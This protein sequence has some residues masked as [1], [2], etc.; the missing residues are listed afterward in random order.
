MNLE[1]DKST[2]NRHNPFL[3]AACS[4][5]IRSQLAGLCPI[6]E[7]FIGVLI[8]HFTHKKSFF[9]HYVGFPRVSLYFL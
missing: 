8:E 5:L 3:S 2:P 6:M 7:R 4:L 9:Q 1:R